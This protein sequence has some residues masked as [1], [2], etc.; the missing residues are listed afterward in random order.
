MYLLMSVDVDV[1]VWQLLEKLKFKVLQRWTRDVT[2]GWF[3]WLLFDCEGGWMMEGLLV[4]F[5]GEHKYVLLQS[6]RVKKNEGPSTS[7]PK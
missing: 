1:D 6:W 2:A 5:Y 7:P 3:R 4:L